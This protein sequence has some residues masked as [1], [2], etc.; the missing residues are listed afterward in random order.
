MPSRQK[1]PSVC[2]AD[3]RGFCSV[4][5]G[6][7]VGLAQAYQEGHVIMDSSIV[8]TA[9]RRGFQK[10]ALEQRGVQGPHS[11]QPERNLGVVVSGSALPWGSP[12]GPCRP[13]RRAR[14]ASPGLPLRLVASLSESGTRDP[15]SKWPR[16]RHW[17]G[18]SH[19]SDG[20]NAARQRMRTAR[21]RNRGLAGNWRELR[22]SSLR[23][24]GT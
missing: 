24:L 21:A 12:R 11:C 16:P 5:T 7:L 10:F 15:E 20:C 9:S 17:P 14:R 1:L 6:Y 13:S 2:G 22:R 3:P 4:R 19:D 18:R 23:A 8:K